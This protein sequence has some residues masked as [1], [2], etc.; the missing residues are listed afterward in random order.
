MILII[1]FRVPSLG[2]IELFNYL[3]VCKQMNDIELLV[4]D[5]HTWNHL[6]EC[7]QMINIR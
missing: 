5:S 3:I 7:R 2:Q 1:P 6:T 4:L